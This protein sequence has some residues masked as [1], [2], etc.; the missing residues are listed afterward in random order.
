MGGG[1]MYKLQM[2]STSTKSMWLKQV[3]TIYQH[4]FWYYSSFM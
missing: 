2:I 4:V 3:I 1:A